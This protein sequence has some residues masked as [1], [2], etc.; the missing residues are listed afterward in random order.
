MRTIEVTIVDVFPNRIGV[1]KKLV[2]ECRCHN[3]NVR[4]IE[5]L[6]VLEESS[7]DQR[8][9]H[10]LEKARI[11]DAHGG[12]EIRSSRWWRSLFERESIVSL[13]T[14]PRQGCIQPGRLHARHCPHPVQQLLKKCQ[15][16]RGSSIARLG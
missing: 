7:A 14:G 1:G 11:D 8:D 12:A 16:F 9:L 2:R 15:P 6:L 5:P 3:R 13:V 10:R 4:V